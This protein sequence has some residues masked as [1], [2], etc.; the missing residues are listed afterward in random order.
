MKNLAPLM[1]SVSYYRYLSSSEVMVQ[2][3]VDDYIIVN[4]DTFENL[5]YELDGYRAALKE[6]CIEYA[7]YNLY[8]PLEYYPDWFV[9]EAYKGR[10]TMCEGVHVFK[11]RNQTIVMSPESIVLRNS[12]GQL[13]YMERDVFNEM[14]DLRLDR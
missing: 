5:Y 10:I 12:F 9:E 6:D 7:V 2:K 13:R 8:K 4:N 1:G 3:S 14:Y 11:D